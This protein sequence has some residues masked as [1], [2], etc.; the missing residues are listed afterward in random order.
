M[1]HAMKGVPGKSR[2]FGIILRQKGSA[3]CITLR[4]RPSI[5]SSYC[6]FPLPGILNPDSFLL[7]HDD[8]RRLFLNLRAR[9]ILRPQ[10]IQE[11]PRFRPPVRAV[12]PHAPQEHQ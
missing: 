8:F 1:P 3:L 10:E 5:F 4:P 12:F 7:G 6:F 11:G 9:R 2:P